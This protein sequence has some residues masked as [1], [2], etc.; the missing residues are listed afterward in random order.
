M[1]EKQGDPEFKFLFDLSSKEHIYYR[2]RVYSLSGAG[3]G[4]IGDA[5]GRRAGGGR[6]AWRR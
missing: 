5:R 2:W 3:A 6:G 4:N 1:A